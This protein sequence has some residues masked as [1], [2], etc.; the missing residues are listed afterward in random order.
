M[1][2]RA[3]LKGPCLRKALTLRY[4]LHAETMASA[5]FPK[6]GLAQSLNRMMACAWLSECLRDSCIHLAVHLQMRVWEAQQQSDKDEKSRAQ[7]KVTLYLQLLDPLP[8]CCGSGN[9]Q[10]A[11]S[12]G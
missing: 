2:R 10:H 6:P 9:V 3:V 5:Q 11:K 8:F 4:A 7:A 1:R 12:F